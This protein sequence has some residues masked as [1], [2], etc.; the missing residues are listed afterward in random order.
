MT[1]GRQRRNA[2]SRPKAAIVVLVLALAGSN[3]WWLYALVDAGVT[4]TYMEAAFEEHRQALDQT[5]ALLPVVA[6]KSVSRADVISAARLPGLEIAPFEKDGF[7]WVGRIG[8]K[9][10]E[11]GRLVEA[12]RAWSPP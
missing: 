5:L 6:R 1:A 4:R 12:S 8:L 10:D 2:M 11:T 3:L 9:F 7:V